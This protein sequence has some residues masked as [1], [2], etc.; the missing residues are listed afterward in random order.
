MRRRINY[1]MLRIPFKNT[2]HTQTNQTLFK[3]DNSIRARCNEMHRPKILVSGANG[4]IGRALC[5]KLIADGQPVIGAVRTDMATGRL[6]VGIERLTIGNIGTYTQ[7]S[8][9]LSGVDCVIHLAARAHMLEA[10]ESDAITAYRQV[11]V[12]GTQSLA[13]TAADMGVRRFIYMSSVKVNGNGKPDPY[14]EHDRP[15]PADPYGISKYE[16]EQV[17]QEI[18]GSTGLELVVLRP[19]L[20]YGPHVKANFLQLL[21]LV[22]RGIP[23]PLASVKNK[24]SLISMTNLIDALLTCIKHPKAAGQTYLVS[25]GSDIS[26]SD[27]V[28]KIALALGKT[29]HVFPFPIALLRL[30]AKIIGRTDTVN[31]IL[32]SLTVNSSKIRSD[33]DWIPPFTMED[34]L[35]E[36]AKWYLKEFG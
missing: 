3:R 35:K 33:L 23:L 18:S 7:W 19:P 10:G 1:C 30:L 14:N 2:Q 36:T 32:D 13:H 5:E 22:A 15:M 28:K 26:V 4:F 29:S 8:A 20:V 6:P 12:A 25:D 11:N 31:R 34:G 17:L 24:R 21:N 9:A 27:L 16:A